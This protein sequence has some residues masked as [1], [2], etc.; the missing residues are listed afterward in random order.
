[1]NRERFFALK[2]TLEP[3]IDV[4][5][6]KYNVSFSKNGDV[7]LS[8]IRERIVKRERNFSWSSPIHEAIVVSNCSSFYSDVEITHTSQ[9]SAKD[10]IERNAVY[11][12]KAISKPDC[13]VNLYY[14]YGDYLRVNNEFDEAIKMFHLFIEKDGKKFRFFMLTCLSLHHCYVNKKEYEKALDALLMYIEENKPRSEIFCT[15]G[16]FVLDKFNDVDIAIHWLTEATKCPHPNT[17]EANFLLAE[18]YYYLPYFLLG[19]CYIQKKDYKKALEAYENCLIYSPN[20]GEALL[21]KDRLTELHNQ[22][23]KTKIKMRMKYLS[24]IYGMSFLL[25]TI[26]KK[27]KYNKSYYRILERRSI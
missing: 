19:K 26:K 14:N 10:S 22:L 17:L 15:L 4:V 27:L 8:S 16:E 24:S 20:D 1:M 18:C 11:L 13:P 23:T 2:N 9:F 3:K 5:Y 25:F 12:K 21:L 6:M 7:S